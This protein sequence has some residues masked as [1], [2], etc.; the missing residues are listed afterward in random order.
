MGYS[1][2][3]PLEEMYRNARASRLVDGAD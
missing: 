3:M 2:D 1:A